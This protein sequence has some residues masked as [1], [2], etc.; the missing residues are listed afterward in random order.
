MRPGLLLYFQYVYVLKE[1]P[2]KNADL[3]SLMYVTNLHMTMF[4]L[5]IIAT[6]VAS[7]IVVIG[8]LVIVGNSVSNI[9]RAYK[10]RQIA[11]NATKID[12][13]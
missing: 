2:E 6:I 9:Y 4:L 12:K 13:I 10:P 8:G 1:R 11:E 5:V 7:I 3:E